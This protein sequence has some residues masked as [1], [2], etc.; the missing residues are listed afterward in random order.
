MPMDREVQSNQLR[1]ISSATTDPNMSVRP[2]T[3]VELAKT[4]RTKRSDPY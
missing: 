2:P 3:D 4:T 1:K